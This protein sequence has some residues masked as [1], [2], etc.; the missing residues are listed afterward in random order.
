MTKT[1]TEEWVVFQMPDKPT[2]EN[3]ENIRNHHPVP[4]IFIAKSIASQI[5]G[6]TLSKTKE[7]SIKDQSV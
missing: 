4:Q 3:D 5:F 2:A 6:E 1:K 7:F